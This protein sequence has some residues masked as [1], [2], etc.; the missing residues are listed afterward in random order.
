MSPLTRYHPA[1]QQAR[2]RFHAE[3]VDEVARTVAKDRVVVVGMA[4]NQPVK[5]ARRILHDE[6]IPYTYLEY[7]NYVSGWKK[8]LALKLWAGWPT[9]PMVFVGGALVGG[10]ADLDALRKAG[11]LKTLISSA[12]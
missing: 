3:V 4:W 7:G 10:A 9:F 12:A 2:E 8:R 11:E 6:E 1:A 5:R